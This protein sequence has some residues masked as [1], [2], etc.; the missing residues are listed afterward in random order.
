MDNPVSVSKKLKL[1]LAMILSL[2]LSFGLLGSHPEPAQ[3]ATNKRVAIIYFSA[4]GTTKAVA[5]KI[6][7]AT[8]GKIIRIRASKPYTSRDL[9]Y[10]EENSR[11][12][13]E[14]ESASTPAKSK[15]RP[16]I[17]NLSAIK[18]AVR[19]AKTVYI[20]YPIWWGQAPHIMYTLVESVSLKGKT[21]VP[22]NTSASSGTGSSA[23]NL[24]KCAI[25]SPKTKWKNGRAFYDGGTQSRINRWVKTIK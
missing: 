22:F 17:R 11:V 1:V 24:K 21:V 6:Q 9:D 13:K 2:A 3:A 19:S 18:K 20:G 8:K 4:T 14:H 25:I 7:K 23:R 15:V 10:T 12:T 5:N 16:K